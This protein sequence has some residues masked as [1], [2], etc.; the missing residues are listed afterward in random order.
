MQD[1][2]MASLS[3]WLKKFL[4]IERSEEQLIPTANTAETFCK[5]VAST[6]HG[7][8]FEREPSQ[9]FALLHNHAPESLKK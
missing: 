8:Q 6:A 2:K 1:Q 7:V 3:G 5:A 4:A 9:F